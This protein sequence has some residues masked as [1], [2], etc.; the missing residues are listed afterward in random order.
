MAKQGKNYLPFTH[1]IGGVE[2][3]IW[4]YSTNTRNGF[5]HHAETE[6]NGKELKARVSYINRTYERFE[7]ETVIKRLIE[8]LPKKEQRK[9]TRAFV[10]RQA[11]K[12]SE[13]CEN[14]INRFKRI[15]DSLSPEAKKFFAEN[16]PLIENEEQLKAV[17]ASMVLA[18]L[19]A[20]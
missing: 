9:W 17:E 8:K 5:C 3:T 1:K 12:V 2:Y 14:Q 18:S 4:C 20:M 16:T 19:L 13:R 11:E 7:F 10:D 6:Y 15:H